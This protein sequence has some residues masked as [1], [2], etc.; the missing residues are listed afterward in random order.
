MQYAEEPPI[1]SNHNHAKKLQIV[2]CL[3]RPLQSVSAHHPSR[4]VNP[5]TCLVTIWYIF[6]KDT[7]CFAQVCSRLYWAKLPHSFAGGGR[8]GYYE[9]V[10]ALVSVIYNASTRPMVIDSMRRGPHKQP[11]QVSERGQYWRSRRN[12]RLNDVCSGWEQQLGPHQWSGR[13]V[14][15]PAHTRGPSSVNLN[16]R[17]RW[18]YARRRCSSE[19]C[20]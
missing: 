5:R 9:H 8:K 15:P 11:I 6:P 4:C 3:R 13:C 20:C 1:Q 7:V 16:L 10:G 19:L 2:H 14:T 17:V 12:A 18:E